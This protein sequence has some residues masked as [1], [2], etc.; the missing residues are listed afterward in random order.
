MKLVAYPSLYFSIYLFPSLPLS[1]YLSFPV[2]LSQSKCLCLCYPLHWM[3]LCWSILLVAVL[4]FLVLIHFYSALFSIFSSQ[5][6]NEKL[7]PAAVHLFSMFSIFL[8]VFFSISPSF[9][10]VYISFLSLSLSHTQACVIC[11]PSSYSRNALEATD[12]SFSAHCEHQ[13]MFQAASFLACW[14]F[15]FQFSVSVFLFCLFQQLQWPLSCFSACWEESYKTLKR[16]FSQ[17]PFW[18]AQKQKH[19]CNNK[20]NHGWISTELLWFQ[21]PGVVQ[22]GSL[23]HGHGLLGHLNMREPWLLLLVTPVLFRQV[24]MSAV[25]KAYCRNSNEV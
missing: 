14:V 19:R 22:A 23:S 21:G 7:Y 16:P 15:P 10:S 2:F 18:H 5:W 25:V 3:P 13:V 17:R 12:V 4:V 11:Q 1:L 8:S 20:M 9:L 24:K 6:M